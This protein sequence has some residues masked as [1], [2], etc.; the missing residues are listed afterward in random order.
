[1]AYAATLAEDAAAALLAQPVNELCLSK[2]VRIGRR[3]VGV[4][5]TKVP[6]V[7]YFEV[8][9]HCAWAT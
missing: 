2:G 4:A 5:K 7:L 3:E 8:C 9:F 6:T 1:M